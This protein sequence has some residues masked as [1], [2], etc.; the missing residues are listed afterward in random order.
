MGRVLADTAWRAHQGVLKSVCV[1]VCVCLCISVPPPFAWLQVRALCRRQ[2]YVRTIGN[3]VAAAQQEQQRRGPP[4][5][6]PMANLQAQGSG[7]AGVQRS[8][9]AG[10]PVL[11]P[12]GDSWS[13]AGIIANSREQARAGDGWYPAAR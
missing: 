9:S 1:R 6:P 13:N 3:K 12:Q 4:P 10:R 5:V 11:L 8:L 2:F 7:G